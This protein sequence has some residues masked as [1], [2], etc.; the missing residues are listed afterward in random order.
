MDNQQ[1]YGFVPFVQ[2]D[3]Q[4]QQQEQYAAQTVYPGMDNLIY[5]GYTAPPNTTFGEFAQAVRNDPQPQM[6]R[7]DM[8]KLVE[9]VTKDPTIG[10]PMHSLVEPSTM[11]PKNI[12]EANTVPVFNNLVGIDPNYQPQQM[13]SIQPVPMDV[14]RSMLPKPVPQNSIMDDV[15]AHL[16]K[17]QAQDRTI[18]RKLNNWFTRLLEQRGEDYI[19]SG[20]LSVDEVSKNAEKILDDMISGR[21]DYVKQAPIILSPVIIDTL[22]DYCANKLAIDKAIQFA[23]GYVYNDF[24]SKQNFYND[25]ERMASL[26]AINDSMSRN[27]T[28]AIA[29]VNQDIGAYDILHKKLTFVEATKNVSSLFSLPNEL[30]NY[31]KQT[32]KRY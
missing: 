21:I 28:Q 10:L 7:M 4:N 29:I 12:P 32:K 11:T 9:P 20:R 1:Y 27:I 24:T 19:T 25:P 26:S 13:F 22:I 8:G 3:V 5:S 17:A 30:N 31:K 18:G 23:L 2:N 16:S 15:T 14:D 6:A